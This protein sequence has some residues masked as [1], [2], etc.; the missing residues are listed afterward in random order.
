MSVRRYFLLRN[1][2]RTIY[3]VP[4]HSVAASYWP[5]IRAVV[6]RRSSGDA[7]KF[8]RFKD[9]EIDVG[10]RTVTCCGVEVR[11]T[12]KEYSLLVFFRQNA[13]RVLTRDVIMR[14][15]WGDVPNPDSRTVDAH[16]VKLRKK[17]EAQPGTRRRVVTVHTL[18]YRFLL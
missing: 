12:P 6:K 3:I 9:I 2:G 1:R 16:I 5:A 17:L 13:D 15:V 4:T 8:P 7:P 14:S 18:G 10:R 11:L